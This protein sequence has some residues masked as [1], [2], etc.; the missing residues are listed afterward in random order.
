M[1]DA[2]LKVYMTQNLLKDIKHHHASTKQ[3]NN[4]LAIMHIRITILDLSLLHL[5]YACYRLLLF[6]LFEMTIDRKFLMFD[7]YM[8]LGNKPKG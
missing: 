3:C 7:M 6:H 4:I 5:T 2:P 8:E 1:S